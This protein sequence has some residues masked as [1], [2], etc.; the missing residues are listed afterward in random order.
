MLIN[1]TKK[2]TI[3]KCGNGH[4]DWINAKYCTT[5]GRL[6]LKIKADINI[7]VCDHCKKEVEILLPPFPVLFCPHCGTKTGRHMKEGG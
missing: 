1:K 2:V 5:C 7:T 4:Y 3:R 6:I